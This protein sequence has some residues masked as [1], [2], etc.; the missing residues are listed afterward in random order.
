MGGFNLQWGSILRRNWPYFVVILIGLMVLSM[1]RVSYIIYIFTLLGIY[2]IGAL[3]LDVMC[4][5]TG[6][7]IFC[8]SAF[9][10]IGGYT[11]ALLVTK[12][13]IP[14]L[15]ALII[16]AG[17]AGLI[18]IAVTYG[19]LLMKKPFEIVVI[20][21]S[22]E[23]VVYYLLNN[24]KWAGGSLGVRNISYPS[25]FG[26]PLE[27]LASQY[28]LT[29]VILSIVVLLVLSFYRSRWGLLIRASRED[30]ELTEALGNSVTKARLMAFVVGAVL[31]GVSG[32]LYG[33]ILHTLTP[34][35][36]TWDMTIIFFMVIVLGGMGTILGP[37]VGALLIIGLPEVLH[38]VGEWRL[39]IFG[40]LL[41]F[42]IIVF[43]KGVVGSISR[44]R[45]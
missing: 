26:Y 36:F 40:F 33:F 42:I 15:A 8:P 20:T 18:A 23:M 7:L 44:G 45:V 43:P 16:G 24:W 19:A 38:A 21:Y 34:S 10:L 22:F 32:T 27:T 31:L 5:W 4:S 3:G 9:A 14:F 17:V 28:V 12:A 41:V 29:L 6:M 13:G 35:S 25:V 39:F 1:Y 11:A 30:W 2:A 37:I